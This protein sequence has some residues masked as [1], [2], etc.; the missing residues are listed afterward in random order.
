MV[1][2]INE[3]TKRTQVFLVFYQCEMITH[4]DIAFTKFTSHTGG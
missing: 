3:S 2:Q 4:F 1:A